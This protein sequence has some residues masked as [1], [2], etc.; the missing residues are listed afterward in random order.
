M[1][2]GLS[3]PKFLGAILVG[4]VLSGVIIFISI[5]SSEISKEKITQHNNIDISLETI[6]SP[7]FLFE[8]VL[9]IARIIPLVVILSFITTLLSG[10]NRP[11]S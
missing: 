9:V 5:P 6:Q 4:L 2:L 7:T 8:L 10:A 3:I 11:E 1:L